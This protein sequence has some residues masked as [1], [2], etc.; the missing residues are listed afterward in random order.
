MRSVIEVNVDEGDGIEEAIQL[1]FMP[2]DEPRVIKRVHLKD[3]WWRIEAPDAT[4][5]AARVE[6]SSEGEVLL[7][8]GGERGLLLLNEITHERWREAYLLLA[9][10]VEV[11][12]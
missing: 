12:E 3:G 7:I 6:D 5:R 10:A 2:I 8:Y 9:K 1:R 11:E 4:V